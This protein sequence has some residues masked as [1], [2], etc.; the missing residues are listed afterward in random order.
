MANRGMHI[1]PS[2]D[3]IFKV[4]NSEQLLMVPHALC[5]KILV[6]N[7]DVPIARQVGNNKIVDLIEMNYWW[8]GTWGDVAAYVQLCLVCQRA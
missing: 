4:M 5:H 2:R 8:R 1:S 3:S 7:H 6:E